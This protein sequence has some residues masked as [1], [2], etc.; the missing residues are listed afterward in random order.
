MAEKVRTLG[1][2]LAAQAKETAV[3]LL[4]WSDGRATIETLVVGVDDAAILELV[5]TEDPAKVA[6]DAP[7]GWPAPFVAA[8]SQHASGGPR[9]AHAFRPLRPGL[10]D[11]AIRVSWRK[12]DMVAS[13]SIGCGQLRSAQVGKS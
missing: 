6:I 12:N 4:T 2:D 5:R 9:D 8:V 13:R 3:C 1:I 11:V 10:C 7:F